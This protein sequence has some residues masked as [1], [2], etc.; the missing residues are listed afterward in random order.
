MHHPL[1]GRKILLRCD[2]TKDLAPVVLGHH[3]WYDGQGGFPEEYHREAE[4]DA[5]LT[6]IVSVASFMEKGF[7]RNEDGRGGENR[8][9]ETN[10]EEIKSEEIG[11]DELLRQMR[12]FSGTRFSPYVAEAAER[13]LTS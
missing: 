3:R 5:V 11:P 7:N 2:S 12:S 10:P 9:E 6:D 13:V 1:L 4:Q 8:L